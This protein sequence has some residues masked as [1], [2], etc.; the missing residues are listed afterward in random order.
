MSMPLAGSP[1]TYEPYD[2]NNV[3]WP[4]IHATLDGHSPALFVQ[5]EGDLVQC[6]RCGISTPPDVNCRACGYLA[7]GRPIRS[8]T[9]RA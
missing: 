5:H 8:E 9:R 4:S 7:K 1:E 6:N 2:P 3:P